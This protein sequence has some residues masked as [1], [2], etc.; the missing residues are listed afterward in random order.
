MPSRQPIFKEIR[1]R[2]D[3]IQDEHNATVV[4]NG[5]IHPVILFALCGVIC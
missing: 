1:D 5:M 4:F 2:R 3:A